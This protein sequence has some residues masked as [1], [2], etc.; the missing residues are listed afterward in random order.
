MNILKAKFY[1]LL[2][3]VFLNREKLILD[4]ISIFPP[5][6]KKIGYLSEIEF[7]IF[8]Y[9][10]Y[11]YIH[12]GPEEKK[13]FEKDGVIASYSELNKLYISTPHLATVLKNLQDIKLIK[14]SIT[15]EDKRKT[16]YI[17]SFDNLR[18]FNEI[19]INALKFFEFED[20]DNHILNTIIKGAVDILKEN[21]IITLSQKMNLASSLSQ[22]GNY[23]KFYYIASSLWISRYLLRDFQI[24][25]MG[26]SEF[27]VYAIVIKN[28]LGNDKKAI[29]TKKVKGETGLTSSMISQSFKK[30]INDGIIT[31]KEVSKFKVYFYINQKNLEK[32]LEEN[33]KIVDA[34]TK[35][36]GPQDIAGFEKFVEKLNKR[37]STKLNKLESKRICPQE[38]CG[39][40]IPFMPGFKFCPYCGEKVI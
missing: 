14:K 27:M 8:A 37:L 34:I 17:L 35:K 21:K 22:D 10:N 5:D 9:F 24:K 7:T 6:Y 38:K 3:M 4:S 30:L 36:I 26:P 32:R 19:N 15:A 31:R 2:S 1:I 39:M 20:S 12:S 40:E 33:T 25:L 28:Y 18:R 16:N 29:T 23:Q 13:N 11:K